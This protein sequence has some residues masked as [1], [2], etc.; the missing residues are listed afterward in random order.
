MDPTLIQRGRSPSMENKNRIRQS[1]SPHQQFHDAVTGLGLDPS[2]TD[3]TFT[4]GKFNT[5]STSGADRYN[6]NTSP[7]LGASSQPQ[8]PPTSTSPDPNIFPSADFTD[9]TFTQD[10][11]I[12]PEYSQQQDLQPSFFGSSDTHLENFSM[13]QNNNTSE[14]LGQDFT[15]DTSFQPQPNQSVNPADLSRMSSPNVATP[16]HLLQPD[17]HP[18]PGRP[19]SPAS[20]AGAFYTPQHSR[21]SSLAPTSAPF[22]QQEWQGMLGTA[23][24]TGHRRAPSDQSDISSSAAPSPYMKQ[25]SFESLENNHS[26][27]LNAQADPND[28]NNGLGSFENFSLAEQPRTSPGPSPYGSPH[29]GPQP[30]NGLGLASD[31]SLNQQMNHRLGQNGSEIYVTH[32]GDS[33]TSLPTSHHRNLSNFSDMGRADQF[34]APTINIEPAPVSRQASFEPDKGEGDVDALSPPTRT[35]FNF[36]LQGV[37][38]NHTAGARIRSLSD[39]NQFNRPTA[40]STSRSPSPKPANHSR[41]PSVSSTHSVRSLSPLPSHSREVSPS[42][43]DKSR[44]ASTSSVNSRDY[45]LDLADPTRPSAS[46]NHGGPTRVQKHPAT[47][48]CNLC[49][50]RFTRAY[51]LRSHLRTHTDERPFVCTVCGKA[52]ARQHD[53]KRHEGLHSGE[54]KF[55]CK[56]DLGSGGQ[57]GCGRRF[58]RADALGRHFRSEAGRV[59]IKPLLDEEAQE[60]QRIRFMEQQQ[61]QLA[62]GLQPVQQPLM[63]PGDPNGIHNGGFMLPAALL[64]QY[65]ALNNIDWNAMQPGADD[66]DLSDVS[67]GMVGGEPDESGYVSGPGMNFA[68]AWQ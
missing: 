64:A 51:N 12:H 37:N 29:M 15:L 1:P 26:P 13:F 65:P 22:P 18:S 40:R 41:S 25:E 52:F 58:A 39:P 56:G 8:G 36:L 16:P 42:R 11:T 59:C 27:L 10:H 44:R 17:G 57:W 4:T 24:F 2:I 6:F 19:S 32:P 48:Q 35:P 53:R 54:K 30:T 20:T 43:L 50:K 23:S 63:M 9:N 60:R 3:S 38:T 31:L 47:F 45:I 7:Y 33:S 61:Q 62:A 68:G 67:G 49:P 21:H 28:Y 55:V 14:G 5:V 46:P 34:P 66:G